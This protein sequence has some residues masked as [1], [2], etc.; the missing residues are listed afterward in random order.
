MSPDYAQNRRGAGFSVQLG[1]L[2]FFRWSTNFF[3]FFEPVQKIVSKFRKKVQDY[4]LKYTFFRVYK[5]KQKNIG[6]IT[7]KIFFKSPLFCKHMMYYSELQPNNP[8]YINNDW[9]KVYRAHS[10]V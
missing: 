9:C 5:K 7:K 10:A 8:V 6:K 3:I 4:H 1:Q 2:I